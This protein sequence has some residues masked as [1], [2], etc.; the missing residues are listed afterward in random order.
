MADKTGRHEDNVPGG[1]YVDQACISCGLCGEYASEVFR[2]S[3]RADHYLVFHQPVTI[4][5]LESA[6]EA[7]DH[8]PVDAIGNDG[9]P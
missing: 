4:E 7:R 9:G 2:M 5:E 1:W 6:E 3:E 8:C